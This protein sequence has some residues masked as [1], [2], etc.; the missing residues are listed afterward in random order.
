MKSI[1]EKTNA[2]RFLSQKKLKYS[3]YKYDTDK[4]LSGMEV[5]SVLGKNP[6]NVFKTLV[7]V[8]ASNHNYVFLVPV[9]EEL[10][11][12]KAAKVVGEKS[13]SM[14]KQSELYPLTGYVHGGSSPLGMKKFFSTYI[15]S[16]ITGCET[17]IFSGGKIGLQIEISLS[18]LSKVLD[19]K[20]ADLAILK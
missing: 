2:I 1:D 9:Y 11:L 16:S 8:G 6:I 13:I 3:V 19:Y 7:T 15:D 12:K 14:I 5:A 20:L 18:E 17:I 4:A 10:D